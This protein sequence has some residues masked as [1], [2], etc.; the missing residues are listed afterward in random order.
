MPPSPLAVGKQF[1][2]MKQLKLAVKKVALFD[3]FE[4]KVTH[5]DKYRYRVICVSD[6]CDWL[7]TAKTIT[8]E[9]STSTVEIRRVGDMHTCSGVEHQGHKQA[10]AALMGAYIEEKIQ[11]NPKYPPKDIIDDV[12]SIFGSYIYISASLMCKGSRIDSHL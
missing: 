8:G 6:I 7:L 10:T 4:I 9:G 3:N 1:D 11:H 2:D 12:H 5:S